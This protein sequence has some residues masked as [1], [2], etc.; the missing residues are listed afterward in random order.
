QGDEVVA[1][2][3]KRYAEKH[4]VSPA[5]VREFYGAATAIGATQAILVTTG[6]Y[7]TAAEAWCSA[8]PPGGPLM[9]LAGPADLP[10]RLGAADIPR[11]R[12]PRAS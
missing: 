8:L 5:Q 3:C 4:A 11:S 10:L 6:R 1:V 7:S 12:S 9:R 2:Q